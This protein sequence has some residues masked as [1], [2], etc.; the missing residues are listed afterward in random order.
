MRH[1]QSGISVFDTP[2][3]VD[4]TTRDRCASPARIE[5]ERAHDNKQP[6]MTRSQHR[7]QSLAPLSDPTSKN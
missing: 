4:N 2:S 5:D 3:A 6:L 7:N 1:P